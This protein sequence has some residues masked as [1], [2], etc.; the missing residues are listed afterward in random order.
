[1]CS[2]TEFDGEGALPLPFAAATHAPQSAVGFSTL[3]SL[4]HQKA[5][6]AR[7]Q[8][9][10]QADIDALTSKMGAS[11][12]G[13]A[14]PS[15]SSSSLMKLSAASTLSSSR[16]RATSSDS[17]SGKLTS[18]SSSVRLGGHFSAGLYAHTITPH[19]ALSA[20]PELSSFGLAS[21]HPRPSS[22]RGAAAASA[23]AAFFQPLTGS[24][25]PQPGIAS[26]HNRNAGAP[27]LS[28]LTSFAG[29]SHHPSSSQWPALHSASRVSAVQV[30]VALF[31]PSI[32]T[33]Q[34]TAPTVQVE[35]ERVQVQL[36][37]SSALAG[38]RALASLTS[39]S[40]RFSLTSQQQQ[41][42]TSIYAQ[43]A[44]QEHGQ[45]R[46]PHIAFSSAQDAQ[47]QPWRGAGAQDERSLRRSTHAEF[48]DEESL[49]QPHLA[50]SSS[51]T[52][53]DY[54]DAGDSAGHSVTGGHRAPAGGHGQAT[55]SGAVSTIGGG[56]SSG[57]GT[58]PVTRDTHHHASSV[59]PHA[60]VDD[61]I[62][63]DQGDGDQDE[64][65]VDDDGSSRS[66][67]AEEDEEVEVDDGAAEEVE[68]DSVDAQSEIDLTADTTDDEVEVAR[69]AAETAAASD[70]IDLTADSDDDAVPA[71][72]AAAPSDEIDMTGDTDDDEPVPAVTCECV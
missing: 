11:S 37:T 13:R 41:A 48:T 9:T 20:V 6:H 2:D 61:V 53:H 69:P 45:Q 58:T 65:E 68:L 30:E 8:A 14:S 66:G 28:S 55:S 50:V 31:P 32:S 51:S 7:L 33:Q 43:Q 62:E 38:D 23:A 24:S 35:V 56:S 34:L 10:I 47:L 18:F 27:L 44:E 1:M 71:A 19:G 29:S 39:S 40:A 57:S 5:A 42:Q 52:G 36:G 17:A 49:L 3:M 25:A 63:L 46:L 12:F 21:L 70:E 54:A 15:E 72:A 60:S 64:V 4:S 67:A 16:P 59:D 22:S 26:G